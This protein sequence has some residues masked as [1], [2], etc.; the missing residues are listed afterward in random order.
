MTKK[1]VLVVSFAYVIFFYCV[2]LSKFIM[3]RRHV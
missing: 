1:N 3:R 2:F